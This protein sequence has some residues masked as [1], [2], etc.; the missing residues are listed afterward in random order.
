[1]RLG[2]LGWHDA[3]DE[4]ERR[5]LRRALWI[6]LG[7]HAG[8]VLALVVT[9]PSF[10]RDVPEAISVELIAGAT[11]G[12]PAAPPPRPAARPKPAPA[13]PKP[14]AAPPPAPAPPPSPAPPAPKAPV[15]VLPEN[16]PKPDKK[17]AQAPAEKPREL[18]QV[19]PKKTR[20]AETRAKPADEPETAESYDDVMKALEEELGD[21]TTEGLLEATSQARAPRRASEST[22]A[23]TSRSGVPMDPKLAAW[24]AETLRLIRSKWVTPSSFR[25]RGLVTSLELTLSA[26]GKLVGEPE[27]ARSSGDPYFD[28]TTVAAL[29]SIG[30]LPPPPHAGTTYFDFHSDEE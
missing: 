16:A 12:P 4:A 9:P 17:V 18:A 27:V 24:Q 5:R 15:K 14:K 25:G 8:L 30:Q 20:P 2:S 23:A 28:D 13:A 19:E 29:L 10:V 6:S 7:I 21:D 3:L 1:M 22:G 26:S 11:L